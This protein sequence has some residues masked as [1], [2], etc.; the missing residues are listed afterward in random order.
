LAQPH[1]R[2]G[3]K[4][5]KEKGNSI[6][7]FPLRSLRPLRY[8]FGW[9]LIEPRSDPAKITLASSSENFEPS[10]VVSHPSFRFGISEQSKLS[11]PV[12]PE[13]LVL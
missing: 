4:G 7:E 13:C 1:Y 6:S 3:A 12:E 2:K 5:A 8:S 10:L 9:L 11:D